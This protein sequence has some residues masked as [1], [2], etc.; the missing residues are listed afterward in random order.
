MNGYGRVKK[1]RIENE[2]CAAGVVAAT[3]GGEI[4]TMIE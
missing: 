1:S 3:A 2:I 4:V